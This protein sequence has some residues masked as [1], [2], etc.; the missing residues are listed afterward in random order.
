MSKCMQSIGITP[1]DTRDYSGEQL[2]HGYTPSQMINTN[3]RWHRHQLEYWGK[4]AKP[5][6]LGMAYPEIAALNASN[7]IGSVYGTM[8][9]VGTHTISFHLIKIA[10]YMTRVH[11]IVYNLCPEDSPLGRAVNKTVVL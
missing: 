10:H 11:A 4:F 8:A 7:A 1:H 3:A 2:M 6:R 5:P 9:V